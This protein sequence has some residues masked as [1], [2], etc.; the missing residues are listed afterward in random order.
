MLG[1]WVEPFFVKKNSQLFAEKII[2]YNYFVERRT[3]P[4]KGVLPLITTLSKFSREQIAHNF[5]KF[6]NIFTR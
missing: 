1:K 5:T 2:N 4:R 3:S 6:F